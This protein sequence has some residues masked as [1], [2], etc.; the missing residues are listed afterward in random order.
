MP[1]SGNLKEL[2]FP[3][4]LR[5]L[6]DQTG[7]LRIVDKMSGD[8]FSFDFSQGKLVSASDADR[9]IPDA[10]ALHSVIQR[11]AENEW[12]AFV[13]EE[14]HTGLLSGPLSIPVDQILLSSLAAVRSPERYAAFLPHPEA[15]F[16]A[17]EET[18]PWLAGDLLAFWVSAE[19]LLRSGASANEIVA[20]LGISLP[21]ILLDLYKLRL[22]GVVM[23]LPAR[24][25]VFSPA[26]PAPAELPPAAASVAPPPPEPELPAPVPIP[27]PPA[28]AAPSPR[29][30]QSSAV[31]PKTTSARRGILAR[32]AAGLRSVLEKMYE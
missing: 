18:T 3:E 22:A 13:F 7:T 20:A 12:A 25:A 23:P 17:V 5:L 14:N 6:R 8:R 27:P 2:P 19:R 1:L 32:I 31:R 28:P 24:P 29:P 4:V 10:L 30:A 26:A 15:R 16:C 9:P 11:L 21:Q